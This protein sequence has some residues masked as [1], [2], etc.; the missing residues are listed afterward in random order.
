MRRHNPN[1]FRTQPPRRRIVI[2]LY[3]TRQWRTLQCPWKTPGTPHAQA[4]SKQL[5]SVRKDVECFFGILKG[6]FRILK[7]AILFH[8]EGHISNMFKTCCV[9]YNILHAWDGLAELEPATSWAS[10]DGEPKA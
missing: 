9:Q 3:F 4:Y 2:I 8:D 7:S 5:E 1:E 6:R 10:Y